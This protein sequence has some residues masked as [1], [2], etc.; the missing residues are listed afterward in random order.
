M[1]P[2]R[3]FSLLRRKPAAP[4]TG[5]QSRIDIRPPALWGQAEPVW[6]SLWSW[7]RDGDAADQHLQDKLSLA[8]RDFCGALEDLISRDAQDL[9]RRAEHARS[10]RELWHLRAELYS[11]VARHRNQGEAIRRMA[12]VNRHFP[13]STSGGRPSTLHSSHDHD[14]TV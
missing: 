14:Q 3:L 7:L 8:R 6:R 5:V 10:L 1:R 11:L 13:V 9:Q 2:S 4:A 12:L